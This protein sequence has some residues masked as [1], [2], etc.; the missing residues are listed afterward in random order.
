M[1]T[2]KPWSVPC[3]PCTETEHTTNLN[4]AVRSVDPAGA[5]RNYVQELRNRAIDITEFKPTL[6]LGPRHGTLNYEVAKSGYMFYTYD[7]ETGFLGKDRAVFM[8]E[9]QGKHFRVIVDIQVLEI[10]DIHESRCPAR[11]KVIK[12]RKPSRGDAGES[13]P[14]L[15]AVTLRLADLSG[16]SLGETTGTTITL[17]TTAAGHGWFIDATPSD[18]SELLPTS[19]PNEWI[20]RQGSEAY[21]KMD[22][23]TVLLHE[24]GHAQGLEHSIDPHDFMATT[25]QP[26]VRRT[27]S[28]DQQLMLMDLAGIFVPPE[29]LSEPYAPIDPGVP[30]A[31]TRVTGVT[32]N[33]RLRRAIGG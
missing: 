14:D 4:S 13:I 19:N 29:S 22:L 3:F 17:D 12:L 30:L 5:V 23:L 32:R 7:P 27:I 20:A 8:V 1:R 9:Y 18:H 31:F 28:V 21:G 33:P 2:K 10:I 6:L 11:D 26:G 16:T 24:Y 15:P 25:L